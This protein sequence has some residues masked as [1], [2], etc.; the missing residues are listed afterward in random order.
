MVF[1]MTVTI[2]GSLISIIYDKTL[3]L[4]PDGLSESAA[5]AMVTT[6]V[7]TVVLG[8][9]DMHEVWANAVQLALAVWL[10]EQRIIWACVGPVIISPGLCLTFA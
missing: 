8:F 7:E 2:R 9:E 1:R 4:S 5:L 6:E 3:T 10:L